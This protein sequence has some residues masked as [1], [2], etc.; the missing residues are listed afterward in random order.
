MADGL[1]QSK[2]GGGQHRANFS[3][4]QQKQS[5]AAEDGKQ[6]TEVVKT[7]Q[8]RILYNKGERMKLDD[9]ESIGLLGRGAF[10]H[11]SLVRNRATGEYFALKKLAKDRIRG[12]K[13]I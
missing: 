7:K 10:G 8:K 12:E 5:S 2:G 1:P 9:F 6:A 4:V 3:Q 11:V 13:H